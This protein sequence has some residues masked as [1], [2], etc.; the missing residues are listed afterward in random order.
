MTY[1]EACEILG[2]RLSD[3]LDVM[4]KCYRSR[5][6]FYHPDNFQD[7][8][9]K[10]HYAEEMSKR[11]NEA[12]EYVQQNYGNRS[13]DEPNDE[14][15]EVPRDDEMDA[16]YMYE[17]PVYTPVF[18]KLT[19]I[20]TIILIFCIIAGIAMAIISPILNEREWES[21]YNEEELALMEDY[22]FNKVNGGYEIFANHT[23][24]SGQVVLP[25]IFQ[26]EPI[27]V[28]ADNAFKNCAEMTEI[29]IPEGVTTIG[30]SAFAKCDNLKRV[31]V[32]D[33]VAKIERV[34]FADPGAFEDCVNLESVSIGNGITALQYHTFGNCENLKELHVSSALQEI[35]SYAFVGCGKISDIYFE[36]TVGQWNDVTIQ[37]N[38]FESNV[39]IT[40]HCTDGNTTYVAN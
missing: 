1:T 29:V 40:I 37:D 33:S 31:C 18:T 16:F 23:D 24:F 11:V 21:Q 2:A 25:T 34:T 39:T 10:L 28:I 22:S 8:A 17:Y 13:G 12:W 9:E 15:R 32:P 3:N 26:D 7:D 5:I 36:G 35:D 4:K 19:L 14:K 30:K 20:I 27:V 38:A 6:K